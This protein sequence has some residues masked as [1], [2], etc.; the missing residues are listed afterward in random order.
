MK[1]R[2]HNHPKM[3]KELRVSE[4]HVI[5]DRELYWELVKRFGARLVA[6]VEKEG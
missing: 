6:T 4:D 3:E 2:M 5:I 1:N